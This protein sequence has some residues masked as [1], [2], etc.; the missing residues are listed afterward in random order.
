MVVEDSGLSCSWSGLM[1]EMVEDSDSGKSSALC[2]DAGNDGG[3]LR[4]QVS[5]L[6]AWAKH[7]GCVIVIA[8]KGLYMEWL[9]VHRMWEMVVVDSGLSCIQ[10]SSHR[11]G[12]DDVSSFII[13][14]PFLFLVILEVVATLCCTSS[15]WLHVRMLREFD[16]LSKGACMIVVAV[17]VDVRTLDLVDMH[18]RAR[19]KMVI[20]AKSVWFCSCTISVMTYHYIKPVANPMIWGAITHCTSLGMVQVN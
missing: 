18:V 9:T 4:N 7:P 19:G 15:L 14:S 5:H 13:L 11:D 17:V 20:G 1:Q 3:G 10:I 16:V 8:A 12:M 2:I 6:R